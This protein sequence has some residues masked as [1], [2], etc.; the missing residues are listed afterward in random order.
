[1][2]IILYVLTVHIEI[3]NYVLFDLYTRHL[4]L[5]SNFRLYRPKKRLPSAPY[6]YGQS[7]AS[8]ISCT[9]YHLYIL[10]SIR[11]QI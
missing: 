3:V 2:V 4:Q 1:M 6:S 9:Q 8:T 11:A 5:R 10:H 7:I